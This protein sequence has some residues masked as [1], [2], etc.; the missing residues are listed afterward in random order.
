MVT[1]STSGIGREVAKQL[2]GKGACVV[3]AVR[4]LQRGHTAMREIRQAFPHADVE[5]GPELM[6]DN[7]ESIRAF[8]TAYRQQKRPLHVLI[9]NAGANYMSEGC[10]A[11]G[12]PLLTQV[13]YV[14]PY[15]LTRLLEPCLKAA[16]Q[17]RVVNVSSVTHRYGEIGNPAAFL[18]TIRAHTGGAYPATKLANVLFTYELQRRLGQHGIQ[19]C[20]V[21]P[22]SVSTAIY[23]DSR[24]FTRQP[25]KWLIQTLYAPPWD[26]AAAVVA[27]AS[28][29]T[30]GPPASQ[31]GPH[32]RTDLQTLKSEQ[33]PTWFFAR[34]CF[35]WPSITH[36]EGPKEGLTGQLRL[37][38]WAMRALS[39]SALDWPLRRIS[40]GAWCSRTSAVPSAPASYDG[41][42]AAALWDLTA[43]KCGMSRDCFEGDQ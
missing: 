20:A 6:L 30:W 2:A 8:A 39:V 31:R 12:I 23:R 16:G 19:A 25:L 40:K 18:S 42:L 10:T 38:G 37:M 3:L 1:G 11:D 32:R 41:E 13:N 9:N 27:A 36:F 5:L 14:G 15:V 7:P 35:A 34:G 24:L 22:G 21:D 33:H 17:A 28:D 4:D 26:G 43:E 29:P